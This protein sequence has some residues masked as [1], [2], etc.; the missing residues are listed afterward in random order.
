MALRLHYL[1]RFEQASVELVDAV[2]ADAL[3][4][5]AHRGGVRPKLRHVDPLTD[6]RQRREPLDRSAAAFSARRARCRA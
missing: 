2:V 3:Q 4:F 5:G 6:V 1:N